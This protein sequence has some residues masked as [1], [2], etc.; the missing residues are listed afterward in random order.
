MFCV[1]RA[2]GV[3]PLSDGKGT[4]LTENHEIEEELFPLSLRGSI[5]KIRALMMNS[6]ERQTNY[7]K[8]S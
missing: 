1:R 8:K 2:G 4:L 3:D 6:T 7:M 5:L